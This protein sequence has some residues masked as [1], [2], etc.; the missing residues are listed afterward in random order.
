MKLVLNSVELKLK[1]SALAV[2]KIEDHFDKCLDEIFTENMKLRSKDLSYII[3][4]MANTDMDI[5]TLK[6]EM[7]GIYTYNEC[8]NIVNDAISDPN[9]KKG[10]V[11]V[12]EAKV[13]EIK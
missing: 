7:S 5:D 1:L 10:L 2:E 11:E 12:V 4:A 8:M 3:W 13:T 6:S 9:A